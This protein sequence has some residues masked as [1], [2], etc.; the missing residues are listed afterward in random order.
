MVFLNGET[1]VNDSRRK[2]MDLLCFTIVICKQ[3]KHIYTQKNKGWIIDNLNLQTLHDV[4]D[5][6]TD[7]HQLIEHLRIS[8]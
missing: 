7:R 3:Y 4:A 6:P 2:S 5:N 1:E 8:N